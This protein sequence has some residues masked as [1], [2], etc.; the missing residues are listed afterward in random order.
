MPREVA[1]AQ[2]IPPSTGVLNKVISETVEKKAVQLGMS[3]LDPIV[4]ATEAGLSAAANA[5]GG[6]VSWLGVAGTFSLF[7][8][9]LAQPTELGDDSLVA[10]QANSDGT[11]N[12]TVGG[13]SASP[14][15]SLVQGGSYWS[16][17]GFS[18]STP[19]GVAQAMAQAWT[20]QNGA[21]GITYASLG[22]T[23][24]KSS[25]SCVVRQYVNGSVN[26]NTAYSPG[27]LTGW[28]GAT[29]A[30]G[31][32]GTPGS[33]GSSYAGSSACVAYVQPA[34]AAKSTEEPLST[35]I[36]ALPAAAQAEPLNPAVAAAVADA[37]WE[38]A[39]EQSGYQGIPYPADNPI[40][41]SDAGSIEQSDPS[42]WPT[43][44][45]ASS[46][47]T[48]PVGSVTGNNPYW[49]PSSA[50]SSNTGS[51]SSSSTGSGTSTSTGTSSGTS[52]SGGT[53][54]GT[55]SGASG[56]SAAPATPD[57]CQLEPSI[58]ACQQLGSASAPVLPSSSASVSLS[59]VSVGGPS[60]AVCPAPSAVTVL[61]MTLSFSYQ[62]ECDFMVRVRPFVLA[63]CGIVAAGIFVSGLKS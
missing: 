32:S 12:V 39:S 42:S 48:S 11:V 36:A 19:E 25:V 24:S 54:T 15:P 52:T 17:Y 22:C 7:A 45:S 10:W 6:G 23:Y 58:V 30:S 37:L 3:V 60:N 47:V 29:C 16:L 63:M 27:N 20:S 57:L 2:Q 31:L 14:F 61:G 34:A 38:T 18:A 53:S 9:L 62:P 4:A 33:S 44:G 51:G 41:P 13:T 35:A 55:S 49:I 59:P 21:G 1:Y 5:A 50:P 56:T 28:S 43:V 26:A 8:T 46:P 40:T